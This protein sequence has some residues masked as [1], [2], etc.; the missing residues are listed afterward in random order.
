VLVLAA[1]NVPWEI[2]AAMRRRFEKRIYIPLPEAEARSVMFKLH[3]GNTPHNLTP[4]DFELLGDRTQ[5]CSGSDISVIVREALMEPLRQCRMAKQFISMAAEEAERLGNTL[6]SVVDAA[7]GEESKQPVPE[8]VLVPCMAYP[9]C[10]DCPMEL[11]MAGQR[12]QRGARCRTCG[13][14]TMTLF[15]VEPSQLAVPNVSMAAFL[16][17]LER[18]R[19]S[20]GEGELAEYEKWTEE[21][22]EEG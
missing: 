5:G 4:E 16:H 6:A 3:I 19:T 13:A 21:F 9:N 20:V 8:T 2:D 12:P 22:G 17:I 18:S 11:T 15:D 7:D 1:T 10:P 14:I